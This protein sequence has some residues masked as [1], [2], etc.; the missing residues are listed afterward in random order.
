MNNDTISWACR[1]NRPY[2]CRPKLGCSNQHDEEHR[3]ALLQR[4]KET[5][6]YWSPLDFYSAALNTIVGGMNR[7]EYMLRKFRARHSTGRTSFGNMGGN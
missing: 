1:Q 6:Y 7:V 4:K 3:Q 2:L 5:G